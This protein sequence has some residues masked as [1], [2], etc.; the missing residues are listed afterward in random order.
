M[1]Y[2]FRYRG[3]SYSS[4][5]KMIYLCAIRHCRG[6]GSYLFTQ[7]GTFL[8]VERFQLYDTENVSPERYRKNKER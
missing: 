2:Q 4:T 7:D 1:V 8:R 5:W 3:E 6:D